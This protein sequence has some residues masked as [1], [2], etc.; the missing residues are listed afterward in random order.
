MKLTSLEKSWLNLQF[1][2]N[3]PQRIIKPDEL[4][5]NKKYYP[6]NINDSEVLKRIQGSI[7]ALAIGDALGA[8][9]EFR[10]RSYLEAHPIKDLQAGGTWGLQI[11]Q[12][13]FLSIDALLCLQQQEQISQKLPFVY[14]KASLRSI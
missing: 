11:G 13:S 4:K 14:D 1:A 6:P 12:V 3:D 7:F 10:P 2:D 9:V 8:P 5:I